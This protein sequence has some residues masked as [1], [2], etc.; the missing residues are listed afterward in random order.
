MNLQELVG[1]VLMFGF[2]GASLDEPQTRTDI[3]ELNRIHAKGVILFDHDIAGNHDRNIESPK[4]LAKLIGDLRNELGDDLRVAIDQEGGAVARLDQQHGFLPTISAAEFGALKEIDQ[5]HAAGRQARQLARLGIDLNFA[6]CVDLAIDPHCP[7]IAGKERAFGRDPEMV[8]RC[9]QIVIDAHRDQGVRCCIKHFPGHGSAMLDSHLGVCDI[10]ETH[11]Q[12]ELD[13]F[14]ELILIYNERIAVMCGHLV[15]RSV[16]ETMP[17]SLS[18][19]HIGMLRSAL[20]FDGVVVTDSLDMRAIRDRF[21]DSE[22]CVH[23]LNA[24]ADLLI[25]GLNAPGFREP[26]AP[27]RIAACICDAIARGRIAGG[28]ARLAESVI[29]LDRFMSSDAGSR[30]TR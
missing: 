6:P 1:S 2:R 11:T 8:L 3:E 25:D 21:G 24:G 26:N 29:R 10:S 27:T 4:Q 28:E 15:E 13:I 23:A 20:G 22:A 14:R 17:A 19:K 30:R 5:M 7:I 18:S 12:E 9:A 16:D